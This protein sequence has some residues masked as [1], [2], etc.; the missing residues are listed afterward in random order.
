M[1]SAGFGVPGFITDALGLV[2]LLGPSGSLTGRAITRV[3]LR[4]L[5]MAERDDDD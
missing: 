3:R 2:L 1:R 5:P 4:P